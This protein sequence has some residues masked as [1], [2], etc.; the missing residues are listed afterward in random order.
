MIRRPPR[1]TRTAT[2]FPFTTRF[3]SAFDQRADRQFGRDPALLS[4]ADSV[5][6]GRNDAVARTLERARHVNASEVLVL[7]ARPLGARK[8]HRQYELPLVDRKSTRLN[9]SH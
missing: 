1:S 9:S 7:F 3:R 6:H 5:R 4:A 2:L 8:S